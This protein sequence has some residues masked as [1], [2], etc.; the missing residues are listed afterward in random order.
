PHEPAIGGGD[1]HVPERRVRTRVGDVDEPSVLCGRHE[2][3]HGLPHSRA[4][5]GRAQYLL[6]SVAHAQTSLNRFTPS[7]TFRRAASSLQSSTP[8]ISLCDKSHVNLRTTAAR[9]FSGSVATAAQ[10]PASGG[11]G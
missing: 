8:P 3:L 4:V 6:D 5:A 11:S 1:Q 10:R 2:P 7:W 9:C